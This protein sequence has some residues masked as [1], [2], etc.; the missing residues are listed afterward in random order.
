MTRLASAHD[1]LGSKANSEAKTWVQTERKAHEAWA[2]MALRKP[3]AAALLHHLV[4]R[5][6][7]QNAVVVSQ[8]TLGALMGAHERT[9]QR[10]VADLVAERWIQAIKLGAAGTVNAYVVNDRVAWGD[11]RSLR[12][13][14]SVFSAMVVANIAEQDSVTLEHN[15]L[16]RIPSLYP[17]ERQLPTGDGEDPPSQPC[18]E[19]LEPDLL[20]LLHETPEDMAARPTL[21]LHRSGKLT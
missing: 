12:P 15:D 19:G 5:M 21:E 16:R 4:A 9:V 7:H 17:G 3:R 14:L 2:R 13:H 20:T 6:G 10:A 1:K 8:K 11:K 18:I